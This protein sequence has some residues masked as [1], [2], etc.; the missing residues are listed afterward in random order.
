MNTALLAIL[1]IASAVGADLEP[2][3]QTLPPVPSESQY[4]CVPPQPGERVRITS[5]RREGARI[6]IR[7]GPFKEAQPFLLLVDDAVVNNPEIGDTAIAFPLDA[8][9]GT[10]LLPAI[11][12]ISLRSDRPADGEK[13]VANECNVRLPSLWPVWVGGASALTVGRGGEPG[14]MTVA[15]VGLPGSAQSNPA[16]RRCAVKPDGG[17]ECHD[18]GWPSR[19]LRI[20]QLVVGASKVGTLGFGFTVGVGFRLGEFRILYAARIKKGDYPRHMVGVAGA[21]N[22]HSV[23]RRLEGGGGASNAK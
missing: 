8:Y 4:V 11:V 6:V 10:K 22:V 3:S 5:V 18:L 13:L 23:I 12:R 17:S 14:A 7:G 15:F 1:A 19:A 2:T 16:T 21:F 20:P 9:P